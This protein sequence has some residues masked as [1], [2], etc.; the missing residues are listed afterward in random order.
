[1]KIGIQVLSLFYFGVSYTSIVTQLSM[2]L[3]EW[4]N[5]NDSW[6]RFIFI[7]IINII[8]VVSGRYH[9]YYR[10]FGT[11]SGFFFSRSFCLTPMQKSTYTLDLTPQNFIPDSH[12]TQRPLIFM[13]KKPQNSGLNRKIL[14][15]ARWFW[16]VTF[17]C[18][19]HALWLV[20]KS[21]Y[22]SFYFW[23]CLHYQG[24]DRWPLQM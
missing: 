10:K 18:I 16:Q 9:N 8:C 23:N 19:V 14:I 7:V 4:Y 1:M 6:Q 21:Q 5:C 11:I 20:Q 17:V 13:K 22:F 2:A 12:W 3:K 15:P 24:I